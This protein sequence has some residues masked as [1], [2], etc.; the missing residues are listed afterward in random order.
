[1]PWNAAVIEFKTDKSPSDPLSNLA[2]IE[3]S[4]NKFAF[5]C[6]RNPTQTRFN[7]RSRVVNV[8]PIQ[9]VAHF[10]AQSVARAKSN[11]LNIEVNAF[12][13]KSI[14]QLQRMVIMHI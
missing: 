10:E 9:A 14:P 3:G 7:R 5:F 4:V 13:K 8:I 12:G 6:F 1:M 11:G 2:T